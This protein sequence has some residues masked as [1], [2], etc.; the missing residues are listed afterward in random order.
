VWRVLRKLLRR[1]LLEGHGWP[2][3][4]DRVNGF[5]CL[6]LFLSFQFVHLASD[7]LYFSILQYFNYGLVGAIVVSV[8]KNK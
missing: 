2:W 6:P 7:M 4:G 8:D 3:A 1:N 5:L